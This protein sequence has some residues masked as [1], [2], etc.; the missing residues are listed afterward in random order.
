MSVLVPQRHVKNRKDPKLNVI[1]LFFIIIG[2]SIYYANFNKKYKYQYRK[3]EQLRFFHRDQKSVHFQRG[4]GLCKEWVG[5]TIKMLPDWIFEYRINTGETRGRIDDLDLA[6]DIIYVT[7][8]IA[9][10]QKYVRAY[11]RFIDIPNIRKIFK[12]M[13]KYLREHFIK[14]IVNVL[15]EGD[16][17]EFLARILKVDELKIQDY[18]NS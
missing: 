14:G 12:K 15:D 5:E 8:D 3:K 11:K 2:I 9:R 17:I 18:L 6:S 13:S 7:F 1:L 4:Y 16:N 10:E